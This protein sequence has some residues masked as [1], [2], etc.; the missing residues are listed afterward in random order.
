VEK[1]KSIPEYIAQAKRVA[2]KF[3]RAGD[4][5]GWYYW[6]GRLE[7]LQ[8]ANEVRL[9]PAEQAVIDAALALGPLPD[10]VAPRLAKALNILRTRSVNYLDLTRVTGYRETDI[11]RHR[12]RQDGYGTLI[13]GPIMLQVDG[14]RWHRVRTT[15]WSNAGTDSVRI[16]GREHALETG[17]HRSVAR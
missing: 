9:T 11:P 3:R 12:R 13:P 17:W 8:L 1:C 5:S 6:S 15:C 2:D 14:K 10:I 4:S 16:G 7:A